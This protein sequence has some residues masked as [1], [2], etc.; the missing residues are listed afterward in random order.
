MVEKDG[1]NCALVEWVVKDNNNNETI[2]VLG[3]KIKIYFYK[4]KYIKNHKKEPKFHKKF[5]S[6]PQNFIS[7]GKVGVVPPFPR[8]ENGRKIKLLF[9]SYS[10][11]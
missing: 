7:C 8:S 5:S 6:L 1:T 10:F 4:I 2:R 3:M 9:F 11:V